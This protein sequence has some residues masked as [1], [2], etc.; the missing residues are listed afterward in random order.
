MS[1]QGMLGS[2]ARAFQHVPDKHRGLV[3]EMAHKLSGND[4]KDTH[5][6]LAKVLRG[7]AVPALIDSESLVIR[8]EQGACHR[9][10]ITVI[11]YTY[12][13]LHGSGP[14]E[15]D[16]ST[17]VLLRHS[18]HARGQRTVNGRDFVEDMR[19]HFARCLGLDDGA[20]IQAR[21]LVFYRKLFGDKNLVLFR[22][23]SD[24]RGRGRVYPYLRPGSRT[25]EL[26][27]L[28]DH[29]LCG[30]EFVVPVHRG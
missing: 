13:E 26:E 4:A 15:Y 19:E 16:A 2:I 17:I 3:L 11:G 30:P 27:W 29:H 9:L 28:Q 18:A 23:T 22:S 12:P 6:R 20:A 10:P 14:K 1:P 24:L 7:E 8:P 25:I 5:E 21:G